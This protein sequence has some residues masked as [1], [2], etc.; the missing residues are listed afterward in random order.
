M[1]ADAKLPKP[2]E[3]MMASYSLSQEH[4]HNNK[5]CAGA[6]WEA[7]GNKLSSYTAVMLPW[8]S[9][10]VIVSH[11]EH[12]WQDDLAKARGWDVIASCSRRETIKEELSAVLTA[13][14]LSV[15]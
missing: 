3:E 9:S 12:N 1:A 6:Y 7:N 13:V 2:L 4:T 10:S 14:A 11:F 5:A 15:A 8:A